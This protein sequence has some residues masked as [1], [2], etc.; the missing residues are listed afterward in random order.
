MYVCVCIQVLMQGVCI[1]MYMYMY[2]GL[3]VMHKQLHKLVCVGIP[4][5]WRLNKRVEF[6]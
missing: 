1:Y 6:V 2:E 5:V 3:L 4:W